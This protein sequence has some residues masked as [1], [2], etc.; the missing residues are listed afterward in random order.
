[1]WISRNTYFNREHNMTT[2][3]GERLCGYMYDEELAGPGGMHFHIW[4]PEGTTK[5]QLR[6]IARD[7]STNRDIVS[8]SYDFIEED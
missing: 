5:E 8:L 7:I 2:A 3:F 1:M 4:V 6:K